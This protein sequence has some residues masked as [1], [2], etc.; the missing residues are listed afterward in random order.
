LINEK[1]QLTGEFNQ[2]ITNKTKNNQLDD[3]ETILSRSKVEFGRMTVKNFLTNEKLST[4]KKNVLEGK[5][6]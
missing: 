3:S 6:I 4:V 2:N 5:Q 1:E